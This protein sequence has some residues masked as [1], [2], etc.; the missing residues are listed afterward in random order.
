M[1][2]WYFSK[3]LLLIP[4][5][6]IFQDPLFIVLYCS[7]DFTEN[8]LQFSFLY[9]KIALFHYYVNDSIFHM[10]VPLY[11]SWCFFVKFIP[12]LF[13]TFLRSVLSLRISE[14]FH[15]I[16]LLQVS[17]PTFHLQQ[18]LLSV[19]FL[20][21]NFSNFFFNYFHLC[22]S[23]LAASAKDIA[24][25]YLLD[26]SLLLFLLIAVLLHLSC[27]D[28]SIKFINS[29]FSFAIC[30]VSF[31]VVVRALHEDFSWLLFCNFLLNIFLSRPTAS[32]FHRILFSKIPIILFHKFMFCYDSWIIN[33]IQL[34]SNLFGIALFVISDVI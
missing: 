4:F 3:W 12:I 34:D 7:I 30:L 20:R 28:S 18:I 31:L 15:S 27:D 9:Q 33:V 1:R 26:S 24:Y 29:I 23:F 17:S 19:I 16:P 8:F 6:E 10:I 25:H 21:K 13:H 11:F 14:N 5:Y 2:T 32:C 22:C